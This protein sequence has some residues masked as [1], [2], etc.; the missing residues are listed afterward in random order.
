MTQR[1]GRKNFWDLRWRL[2]AVIAAV[3][4]APGC[5]TSTT[6]DA[7]PTAAATPT[8]QAP[9]IAATETTPATISEVQLSSG[10]PRDTGTFPN[11]NIPPQSAAEQ[12][13][14]QQKAAR[15]A[16]LKAAQSGQKAP[17]GSAGTSASK[18]R[19]KKLAA[20]HAT[21]ALEQIEKN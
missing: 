15:L 19:L 4:L 6:G 2:A 10:E 21:E 13:S 20:S 7:A 9:A 1:L 3:C 12:I 11:L 17:P 8:A 5:A 16:E 14:A 18:A